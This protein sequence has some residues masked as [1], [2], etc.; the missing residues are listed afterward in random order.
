MT[1]P[2]RG[3]GHFEVDGIEYH[4]GSVR[5]HIRHLFELIEDADGCPGADGCD[6]GTTHF[7]SKPLTERELDMWVRCGSGAILDPELGLE[8]LVRQVP[9]LVSPTEAVPLLSRARRLNWPPP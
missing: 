4:R 2:Q 7:L 1:H 3:W 5:H 9:G 8:W 6:C